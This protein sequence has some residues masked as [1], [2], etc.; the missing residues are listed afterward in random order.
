MTDKKNVET[1]LAEI[2]KSKAELRTK[3]VG[4]FVSQHYVTVEPFF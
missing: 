4:C 2:L 1:N 3:W